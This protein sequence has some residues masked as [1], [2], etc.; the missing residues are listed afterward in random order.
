[1]SKISS[2]SRRHPAGIKSSIQSSFPV[3]FH[4]ISF[5]YPDSDSL[6]PRKNPILSHRTKLF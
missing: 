2:E 5:P 3:S 1:M 4:L 6:I